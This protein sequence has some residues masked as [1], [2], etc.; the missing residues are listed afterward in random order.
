MLILI[1]LLARIL[2][3][4]KVGAKLPSSI[5]WLDNS[6]EEQQRIR[7]LLNL[8]A[9]TESRDELGIGRIRDAFSD[10]LFPGTST[11]HT[12]ARYF[13]LVPWCFQEAE[14]R[15]LSGAALAMRVAANE[16]RV[17]GILKQAGFT[18]GIIGGRVGPAVKTL[19]STVYWGALGQYRIRVVDASQS[20]LAA[21]IVSRPD[22][23]AEEL[24]DRADGPWCATLPAVPPGFP[25]ALEGG[26]DLTGQEARWLRERILEGASG[27]LLEHLVSSGRPPTPGSFAPW[28]DPV[29]VDAPAELQSLLRHA[30]L[31]S[32]SMHGAALLYNLLVAEQYESAGL[33]RHEGKAESYRQALVEWADDVH[34]HPK[35]AGW[36]RDAM[37]E[38]VIAQNPRVAGNSPMRRFVDH[39][40]DAV[41]AGRAAT[42]T[43]N[44][45]LRE[46]VSQRERAVKKAQSRLVNNKLLQTWSGASGSGRLTYRWTQVKR[47]LTDIHDG[48]EDDPRAS[49]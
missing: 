3:E 1:E 5:A 18:A 13:V 32:L 29:A 28:A 37:W 30:E 25:D 7:E 20:V 27:T 22:H 34:R 4:L 44:P 19:P 24:V 17:L 36:D 46:L 26:L 39:W 21:H 23:E 33:T 49:A 8:F 45:V 6:R 40:L 47:L 11:L 10:S 35:L 15:R 12:R 31:F 9:E 14:R 41:C 43:G 16:R 42:M 38:H 2:R 48:L